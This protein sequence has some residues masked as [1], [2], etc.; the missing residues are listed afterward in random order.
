M[1]LPKGFGVEKGY[2]NNPNCERTRKGIRHSNHEQTGP[3]HYS[4]RKLRCKL[5]FHAHPTGK[6]LEY[7]Y[8]CKFCG[9]QVEWPSKGE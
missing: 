6:Y 5:G 1:T 4:E 3:K 7:L 8:W 2:C 9:A